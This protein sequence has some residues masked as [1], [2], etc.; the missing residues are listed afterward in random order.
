MTSCGPAV[1]NGGQKVGSSGELA[2][3]MAVRGAAMGHRRDQLKGDRERA[4]A[5]AARQLELR[6]GWL[7][8]GAAPAAA[9][10]R[11]SDVGE[12]ERWVSSGSGAVNDV[13]QRRGGAL[14]D[15]SIPDETQQQWTT[16]HDFD[17]ALLRDGLLAKK[18]IGVCHE[19]TKST[20]LGKKLPLASQTCK[21]VSKRQHS[22]S[23]GCWFA[24]GIRIAAFSYVFA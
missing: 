10:A 19:E 6:R 9:P 13:E 3:R 24:L 5:A 22:T 12:E 20:I 11:S 1:G 23:N 21:H 15:R 4:A 14:P 16:R 17:E 2:A 8:A 7:D 18:T